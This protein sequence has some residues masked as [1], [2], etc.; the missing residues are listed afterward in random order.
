MGMILPATD[1]H[2]GYM[3]A[4]RKGTIKS[5]EAN[6]EL[7]FTFKAGYIDEETAQKYIK[8]VEEILK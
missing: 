6:G 3:N 7:S 2:L 4:K 5:L 1:E 8:K